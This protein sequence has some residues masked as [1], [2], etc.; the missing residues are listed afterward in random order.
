[1]C[2]KLKKPRLFIIMINYTKL[3]IPFEKNDFNLTGYSRSGVRTGIYLEEYDIMMDGGLYFDRKPKMILVTHGHLDHV[4]NLYSS[5]LDN[6][7]KPIVLAPSSSVGFLKHYLNSQH[8]VSLNKKSYFNKYKMI[9]LDEPYDVNLSKKFRIVPYTL[10][11]RVDTLGFGI[12]IMG[13]KL[14]PR[15]KGKTQ[16]ELIQL[17]RSGEELN[18]INEKKFI[19]FC[20]DTSSMSLNS[21]PFNDY[22]YI[23]IECTFL[24]PDHYHEALSR[25]HLHY[26]DLKPFFET[27]QSTTFIL[28]HFSRRYKDSKIKEFFK[29]KNHSNVKLFI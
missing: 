2:K 4:C 5:L 11:H 12:H 21:L 14:D 18:I 17:K 9:G 16:D 7:N 26:Q 24:E 13:K 25:K 6:I 27:N 3:S 29:E 23:I 8:T 1:M 19:M 22:S 20:G 28:I 10:D 15:W